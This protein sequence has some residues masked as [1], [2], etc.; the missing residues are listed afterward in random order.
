MRS[1]ILIAF[2]LTGP[3]LADRPSPGRNLTTLERI[4]EAHLAAVHQARAVFASQRKSLPRLGVY[5]DY[6]AV[7]HIHAED[8]DHTKGTRPEVLR[9][10]R[11]AG[12]S[13]VMFTDHRG[14]KPEHL[15]RP[16]RRHPVHRGFGRRSPA[17]FPR[18]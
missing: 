1:R 7:L 14:P 13:V 3:M 17:A 16:S 2:L 12:V 6:R 10:A 4:E 8:A 9:A 5:A 15:D 18:P 11:A